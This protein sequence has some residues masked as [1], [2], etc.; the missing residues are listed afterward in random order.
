ME[1]KKTTKSTPHKMVEK[2]VNKHADGSKRVEKTTAKKT[3]SGAKKVEHK[4]KNK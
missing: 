1:T 2:K 3:A 4:V